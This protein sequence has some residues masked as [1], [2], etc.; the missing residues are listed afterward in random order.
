MNESIE[1][2]KGLNTVVYVWPFYKDFGAPGVY[3][4]TFAGSL[5]FSY[6]YAN[7]FLQP[8]LKRL[9]VWG[10]LIPAVLLSYHAALWECW[11]WYFN[12]GVAIWAHRRLKV[13]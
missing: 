12:L 7:T 2:V 11:F 4:L 10:L 5:G 3:L 8:S 13:P 1:K 6:Y 9:A